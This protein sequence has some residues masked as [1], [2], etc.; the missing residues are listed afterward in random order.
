MFRVRRLRHL[1]KFILVLLLSLG[2]VVSLVGL[3]PNPVQAQTPI[4]IPIE[5]APGTSNTAPVRLSGFTVLQISSPPTI[6][7]QP[8]TIPE[9]EKTGD[10][11]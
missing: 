8:R 9:L 1:V 6:P 2:T 10:T 11:N 4:P 3:S 5:P 7:D